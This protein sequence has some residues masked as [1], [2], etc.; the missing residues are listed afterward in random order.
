M[1]KIFTVFGLSAITMLL[2]LQVLTPSVAI[3]AYGDYQNLNGLTNPPST[4]YN[5]TAAPSSNGQAPITNLD[6]ALAYLKSL[7]GTVV[8]ILIG[9]AVIVFLY[10]VLKFVLNAGD[11]G[12]RSE[13]KTMMVYG[14]IGIVVMVS[15]W[16]LVRFVQNTFNLTNVTP[17]ATPGIPN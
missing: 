13:G 15:V 12:A 10:G 14:I 16:G 5:T 8:P 7:M 6:S 11:E 3:A 4:Q 2:F 17:V 9:L 1:K